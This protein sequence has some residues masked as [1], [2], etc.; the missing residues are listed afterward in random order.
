[1]GGLIK[2]STKTCLQCK[3]TKT[4]RWRTKQKFCSPKCF[5]DWEKG[6]NNPYW[7]GGEVTFT[8][9]ECGKKFKAPQMRKRTAE[10]FC[11]QK[12]A[13]IKM[14]KNRKKE[15]HPN[16]SGGKW[17]TK[18]GYIKIL[19]PKGY[20]FEHRVVM[21]KFLGR[22]LYK[23]EMVH[24]INGVKDDN[25]IE[26]LKLFKNYKE[27]SA[28]HQPKGKQIGQVKATSSQSDVL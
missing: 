14:G 17:K 21:E 19:T 7:K 26:N 2:L 24:H 11:N 20:I 10:Q 8:C 5:Q 28:F 13:K 9:A 22:L 16:W 12:C 25:R 23:Q 1:M 27:H 4:L 15:K 18:M 6:K 3:K